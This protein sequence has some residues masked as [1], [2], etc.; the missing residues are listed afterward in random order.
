VWNSAQSA[1]LSE[2]GKIMFL[3][4]LRQDKRNESAAG[5]TCPQILE[6]VNGD[7]AVVGADMTAEAIPAMPPGP[8]IG[9][10]ERVV[11]IP[12]HILVDARCDIP[13]A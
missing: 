3:R 1:I 6:L 11:R 4:R 7:Y 9:P 5:H 2:K 10:K 12:R 13:V 8:G